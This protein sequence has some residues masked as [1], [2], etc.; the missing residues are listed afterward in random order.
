MKRGY[1]PLLESDLKKLQQEVSASKELLH[2]LQT[3]VST[4]SQGT[5]ST[6][7]GKN[8]ALMALVVMIYFIRSIV[9]SGVKNTVF[10]TFQ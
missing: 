6:Y 2:K 7:E 8:S 4:Y 1:V 3:A 9:I 10:L 5:N